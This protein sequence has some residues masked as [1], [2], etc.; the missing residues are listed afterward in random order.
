MNM[1]GVAAVL[2][3]V[4]M[5]SGAAAQVPSRQAQFCHDLNRIVAAAAEAPEPFYS[6]ERSRAAPPTLGIRHCFRAGDSRQ[7][8]WH[9]NQNLAPDH[10]T[11][12]ALAERTR[13]CLPE[14]VALPAERRREARFRVGG[15]EITIRE[16]GGPRAHVGRSLSYLVAAPPK[17]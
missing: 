10:L 6:L 17:G 7:A 13:T 3:W 15:V 4:A 16:T 12:E 5:A 9:C 11:A 2:A 14:A 8:Y 1:R